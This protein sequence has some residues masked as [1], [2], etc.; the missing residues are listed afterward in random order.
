MNQFGAASEPQVASIKPAAQQPALLI[1]EA[2]LFTSAHME[3]LAS[4]KS[5][6]LEAAPAIIKE[7][8]D[9]LRLVMRGPVYVRKIQEKVFELGRSATALEM[10]GISALAFGIL[11]LL[12][13]HV[14]EPKNFSVSEFKTITQAIDVIEQLLNCAG[15]NI[16]FDFGVP[17]I[18]AVDDDR[19]C[20]TVASRALEK[21]QNVRC[22]TVSN[23][24]T[25]LELLEENKFDLLLLDIMLPDIDGFEL[26]KKARTIRLHEKTPVIFVTAAASFSHRVKSAHAGADDFISKPFNHLELSLKIQILAMKQRLA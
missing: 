23:A 2:Q 11:K 1:K 9:M 24:T 21:V 18:L 20:R 25:A 10:T 7:I 19:V 16:S 5:K 14:D 26:C 3:Q 13:E 17:L 15:K 4:L 6:L 22:I 8:R 12:H